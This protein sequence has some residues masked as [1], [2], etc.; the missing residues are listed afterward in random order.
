MDTETVKM[1]NPTITT[2]IEL[3]KQA[4][5]DPSIQK[6]VRCDACLIY[7]RDSDALAK[8]TKMTHE[9]EPLNVN[10]NL[11]GYCFEGELND[12]IKGEHMPPNASDWEKEKGEQLAPVVDPVTAPATL[13]TEEPPVVAPK[14]PQ[15]NVDNTGVQENV[16]EQQG[17]WQEV[18]GSGRFKCP[19]CGKTRN[20]KNK[21]EKHMSD[22]EEDIDDASFT[23][24]E[25]PYQ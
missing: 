11:C 9:K 13:D 22:H 3:E 14:E 16:G 8:H 23:C 12:H 17:S 18:R 21:M 2:H 24:R 15:V 4:E 5:K 19:I 25:C 10:C 6:H 7:L 20:T 1:A